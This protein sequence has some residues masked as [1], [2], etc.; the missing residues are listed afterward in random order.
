MFYL[1]V[2]RAVA[3]VGLA[4]AIAQTASAHHLMGGEMPGSTWQGLLSGLGHPIIGIDHAAFVIACGMMAQVFDRPYLLPLLFVAGTVFG[5]LLHV[6][7]YALSWSE[8]AITLT[9]AVAA[10]ALAMHARPPPIVIAPL[11]TVAGA[12]H[13]YAYGES[14]V[15]SETTPLTAYII[16]FAVIQYCIAVGSGAVLRLVIARNFVSEP[17]AIRLVGGALLFVAAAISF[18][19][20]I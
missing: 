18:D 9:I 3:L 19:L 2:I 17:A 1:R 14:V 13:G 12:L 4:L 20:F 11:L 8:P 5:C 7:G 16:G 6:Q 10:I 15:G